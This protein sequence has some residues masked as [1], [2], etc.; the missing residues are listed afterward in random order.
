[1]NFTKA[2]KRLFITQPVLS[3]HISSL[4]KELD[5]PL[6]ARDQHRIRLTRYG[7]IFLEHA[8]A[9]VEQYDKLEKAIEDEKSGRGSCLKVGYLH[10]GHRD[11]VRKLE[12][13]LK[14]INSSISIEIRA[15]GYRELME[16]LSRNEIDVA[17]SIDCD[18]E[19][20][21]TYEVVPLGSDR[22]ALVVSKKHPLASSK[23]VTSQDLR[24][25]CL[26][27]PDRKSTGRYADY[28]EELVARSGIALNVAGRYFDV[29]SRTFE[30]VNSNCGCIIMEHLAQTFDDETVCIPLLESG[31]SINF[32]II[33]KKANLN[34]AIKMIIDLAMEEFGN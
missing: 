10:F 23:Y 34:P 25:I 14:E 21:D 7:A 9:I 4:E 6:F 2:A 22:L 13:Q 31:W 27:L 11:L 16:A 20:K 24:D 30:V 1:M 15:N 29:F 12:S 5:A 28:I 8:K 19:I 18:P 32:A 17:F 33:Y 26:Y 3:T